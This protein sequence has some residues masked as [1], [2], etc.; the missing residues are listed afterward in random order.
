VVPIRDS[1]C[2]FFVELSSVWVLW[3]VDDELASPAIW[4][5]AAGVGVVPVCAM[6]VNL[7]KVRQLDTSSAAAR[8]TVKL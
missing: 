5:L 1:K 2:D 8:L 4:I 3:V 6:L 7:D